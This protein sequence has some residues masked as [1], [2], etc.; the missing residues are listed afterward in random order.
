VI[1][2]V[3]CETERWEWGCQCRSSQTPCLN[4]PISILFRCQINTA[5][6]RKQLGC[7][8]V[9]RKFTW[10][11]LPPSYVLPG[12]RVVFTGDLLTWNL[13]KQTHNSNRSPTSSSSMLQL[14]IRANIFHLKVEL[15]SSMLKAMGN[16]GLF[17][18]FPIRKGHFPNKG[19]ETEGM[20]S[21]FGFNTLSPFSSLTR[22]ELN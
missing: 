14:S 9:Q 22:D 18:M 15:S 6:M 5:I 4:S 12:G 11:E 20:L 21:A 13:I 17:V 19:L 3:T 16:W 8:D 7:I 10:V 1:E 2:D